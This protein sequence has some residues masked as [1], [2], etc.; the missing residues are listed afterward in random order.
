MSFWGALG[1]SLLIISLVSGIV[2]WIYMGLKKI[3]PNFKYW[4][5]YTLFKK[6]YDENHV[7]WC[8]RAIKDDMTEEDAMRY[9]LTTGINIKQTKDKVYVFKEILKRYKGGVKNE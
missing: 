5:K 1:L 4:Y 2:Y 3:N 9:F 8:M 7:R 6:K